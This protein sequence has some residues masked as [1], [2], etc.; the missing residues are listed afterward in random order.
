MFH[1]CFFHYSLDVS[2]ELFSYVCAKLRA[3]SGQ[4]WKYSLAGEKEEKKVHFFLF[5]WVAKASWEMVL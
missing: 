1:I 3:M 5:I 4:Y 2:A